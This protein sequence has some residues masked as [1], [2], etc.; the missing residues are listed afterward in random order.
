ML[1]LKCHWRCSKFQ[2]KLGY[3][4]TPTLFIA[5]HQNNY[6]LLDHHVIS[7]REDYILEDDDEDVFCFNP[8]WKILPSFTFVEG[9]GPCVIAYSEHNGGT[10]LFMVHPCQWKHNFQKITPTDFQNSH[11]TTNIKSSKIVKLLY[12]FLYVSSYWNI[13][14]Y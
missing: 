13:S 7:A 1:T 4:P 2:H 14:W 12:K 11:L 10:K 3:L 8:E 6:L 9:K 5:G